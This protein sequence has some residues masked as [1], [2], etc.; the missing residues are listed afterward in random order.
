MK[1]LAFLAVLSASILIAYGQN[2]GIGISNPTRAKLEIN[3][4]PA[5]SSTVAIFG[6]EATGISIQ[7]DWPSIGF[8][9]YYNQ[10][11]KYIGNGFDAVQ[12][13][14]PY[15]GGI[16]TDL[17]ASGTTN[18]SCPAPKRVMS[19]LQSGAIA[20]NGSAYNS[21]FNSGIN[22]DTYI[23]PG[24]DGG[25]VIINDVDNSE[26]LM[27]GIVR[28]NGST[29]GYLEVKGVIGLMAHN[30]F[31]GWRFIVNETTNNLQLWGELLN[32][33]TFNYSNG[34]YSSI[35]DSRLKKNII[36]L[37]PLLDKVMQLQAVEYDMK[38][39]KPSENKTIGFLAQDVKKLFPQLVDI[40]PN[41]N[42]AVPIKDLHV[43]NYTGFGVIAIK[44]IQEQQ[45]TI[46]QLQS[47]VDALEAKVNELMKR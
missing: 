13:L 36:E 3:G 18:G 42:E 2:V 31:S 16:Y 29:G 43:M 41:E 44:A 27:R 30:R 4:T 45:Q 19:I 6:G 12:Y 40:I 32:L 11:S 28:L 20:F 46:Q 38:Y 22:E 23:R 25:N 37:E 33:G 35:S 17:F 15:N 5:N 21:V 34:N 1:K 26:T 7:R 24:K 39:G 14:D 8:N 10:G 9:Q 47:K